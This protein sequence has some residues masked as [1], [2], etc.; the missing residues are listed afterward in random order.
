M[1]SSDLYIRTYPAELFT[2]EGEICKEGRDCLCRHSTPICTSL[3][4]NFLPS[5]RAVP[6]F[7]DRE[8][9]RGCGGPPKLS[10]R[11]VLARTLLAHK[12]K[13][14]HRN[15]GDEHPAGPLSQ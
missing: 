2:A 10:G 15:A 1:F 9:C 14:R 3:C 6:V 8:P 4:E 13:T 7:N 11:Q 12:A 5:Y